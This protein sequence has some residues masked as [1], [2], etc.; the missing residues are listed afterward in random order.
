ML[1][2]YI[3]PV[4]FVARVTLFV[5]LIQPFPNTQFNFTKG[6]HTN[7][8]GKVTFFGF[9]QCFKKSFPSV[10][11]CHLPSHGFTPQALVTMEAVKLSPIGMLTVDH[12][13]STVVGLLAGI[14]P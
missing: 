5:N 6:F 9:I 11:L 1:P 3:P 4:L 10:I 7:V 2:N 14:A 12:M 8:I 13:G